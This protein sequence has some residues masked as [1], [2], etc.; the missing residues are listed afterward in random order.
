ME[1]GRGANMEGGRGAR[2][3]NLNIPTL[4]REEVQAAPNPWTIRK[5]LSNTDANPDRCEIIFPI[6]QVKE[7]LLPYLL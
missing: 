4:E 6:R 5:K 1:G 3:I 7:N 2:D